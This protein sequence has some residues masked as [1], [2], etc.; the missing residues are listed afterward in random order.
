MALP[1]FDNRGDLP[2]G[3][4]AATL[5]EVAVRFGQGEVRR[6]L[7]ELL[8]S[9][10]Q[11]AAATGKLSRFVIFGSFV[12]A[13]ADPRDIDVVMVMKDDFSLA[14]FDNETRILF[15]HQRAEEEIGASIFWV[16]PSV[17]LRETL[18][19]FPLG[20]GTK[21]DLTHRGIVEVIL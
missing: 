2:D 14:T 10:H 3:L 12:T 17:L 16:C 11:K 13:K 5:A 8:Q 9:I 6:E 20:W 7:I 4:H 15:D 1:E 18:D 21:R 19:E